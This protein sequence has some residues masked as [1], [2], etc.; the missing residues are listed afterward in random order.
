MRS[1]GNPKDAAAFR[2][3]AVNGEVIAK[4]GEK[5]KYDYDR[6]R[7]PMDLFEGEN[8][9]SEGEDPQLSTPMLIGD[10]NRKQGV[11]GGG[12]EFVCR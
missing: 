2:L 10:A 1:S 11:G 3:V 4:I 9:Q 6:A 12:E 5:L 8:P 7:S